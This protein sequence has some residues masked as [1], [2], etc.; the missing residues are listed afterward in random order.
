MIIRLSVLL[1]AA[2]VLPAHA[3]P[4]QMRMVEEAAEVQRL[5]IHL[6]SG[7][8][9]SITVRECDYCELRSLSINAGTRVFLDRQ[10]V[11]LSTVEKYRDEGATILF[12]PRTGVVTRILLQG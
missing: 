1:F 3:V 10:Q 6:S 8:S 7:T 4:P 11:P 9:G 12:D 2:L 5:D